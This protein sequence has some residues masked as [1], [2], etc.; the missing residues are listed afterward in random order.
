MTTPSESQATPLRVFGIAGSLR[1]AS[2]NRA[3][4]RAA[5]DLAPSGMEIATFD[6]VAEIPLY[7]ADVES[8]GDPDPVVALKAAIAEADGLLFVTPEYNYSVPGVLKNAVD[9]ASRPPA[10][11]VLK[12]KPA[13]I[14]GASAG[15]GG[16]MRAQYHLRQ[17]FVFTETIA[18]LKPEIMVPSAQDKFDADGRLTDSRTRE[19]VGKQLA[20]FRDWIIRLR[21]VPA[22][23]R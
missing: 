19:L 2:F 15:M 21:Q 20:A 17:M 8:R 3:L 5:R 10:S 12:G 16:T 18:L 14:M 11:T 9:W 1:A 6:R 13:A 4:L 22:S 7:N 23:Q